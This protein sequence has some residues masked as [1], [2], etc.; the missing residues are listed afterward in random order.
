M[1]TVIDT[2]GWI[3]ESRQKPKRDAA[4]GVYR[5][6]WRHGSHREHWRC[7]VCGAEKILERMKVQGSTGPRIPETRYRGG[8]EGYWRS[9]RPNCRDPRQRELFGAPERQDDPRQTMPASVVHDAVDV[10]EE[11]HD[12]RVLLALRREAPTPRH[13]RGDRAR[14]AEDVLH[15]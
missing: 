9:E 13:H 2:S 15:E 11:D 14:R 10:V 1:A 7:E 5:H 6:K 4:H 8:P 3:E 12:H